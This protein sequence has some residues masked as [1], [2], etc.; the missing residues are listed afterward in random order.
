MKR[1]NIAILNANDHIGILNFW[2]ENEVLIYY[3]AT[4][5]HSHL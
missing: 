3:Q 5:Y 2:P 4:L 1:G